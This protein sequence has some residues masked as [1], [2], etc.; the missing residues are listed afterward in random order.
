MPRQLWSLLPE[1]VPSILTEWETPREKLE[2]EVQTITLVQTLFVK[3]KL[4][5]RVSTRCSTIFRVTTGLKMT[6][7]C[8]LRSG[9]V[10]WRMWIFDFILCMLF[11]INGTIFP[12]VYKL[13]H[14][15]ML[16]S[17]YRRI[18]NLLKNKIQFTNFLFFRVTRKN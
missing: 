4:H 11:S 16:I 1:S 7:V 18:L 6:I 13:L 2:R 3:F 14:I 9:A 10:L 12:R 15:R 5:V 8:I 17:I